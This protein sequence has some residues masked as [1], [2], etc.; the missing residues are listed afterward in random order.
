MSLSNDSK[1]LSAEQGVL[2]GNRVPYVKESNSTS[3]K[4]WE[5]EESL[6]IIAWLFIQHTHIV[7][8]VIY[9]KGGNDYLH[10]K[11]A[12]IF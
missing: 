2:F 3:M 10:E 9:D 4:V 8:I 12:C 1:Q 11:V 7:N 6:C 5:D